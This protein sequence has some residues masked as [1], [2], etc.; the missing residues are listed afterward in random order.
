M[1]CPN[2]KY[3]LPAAALR[4]EGARLAGRV[5]SEAKTAANRRNAALPRP[6]AR[7]KKKPRK[8]NERNLE[9]ATNRS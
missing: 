3:E 9:A 8:I 1:N 4:A 7:G 2:C 5:K 6:G